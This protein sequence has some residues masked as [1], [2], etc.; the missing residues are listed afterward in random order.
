[1]VID[2]VRLGGE[3][4]I[5]EQRAVYE[6]LVEG[7]P[8]APEA[9]DPA[10]SIIAAADE[11]RPALSLQQVA[12]AVALRERRRPNMASSILCEIRLSTSA[13]HRRC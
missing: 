6:K 8:P 1:M 7:V 2:W 12:N 11:P 10:A 3:L 4:A 13:E 9:V 5:Q